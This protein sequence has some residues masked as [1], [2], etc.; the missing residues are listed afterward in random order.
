MKRNIPAL[1]AFLDSR[2]SVPHAIGREANDCVSFALAAAE[3]QLGIP[4]LPE[5]RWNSRS[6]ALRLLKRFGSLE[7][8]FDAHFERVAPAFA[9]RG[10]IA[11]VEDADFGIHPM[12]VEGS[13]LVCPG[14]RGNRRGPRSMMVCAW[15]VM[16]FRPA[17][18]S[19]D[20]RPIQTY[21]GR[22]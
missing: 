1:I 21:R 20:D 4:M 10:D 13:L 11:G 16:S 18:E 3:A 6:A 5:L 14:D 15:D 9:K 19:F 7:A 22:Q 2:Q 12:I 8:A 17:E